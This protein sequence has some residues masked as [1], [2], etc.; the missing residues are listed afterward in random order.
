MWCSVVWC[1]TVFCDMM[2]CG[3]VWGVVV[4]CCLNERFTADLLKSLLSKV[5]RILRY[6]TI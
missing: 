2:Y 4:K 1:G 5:V 6:S 3:V